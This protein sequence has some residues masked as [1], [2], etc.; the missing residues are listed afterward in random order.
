M[1][2]FLFIFYLQF[3]ICCSCNWYTWLFKLFAFIDTFTSNL[4]NSFVIIVSFYFTFYL[5]LLS[6]SRFLQSSFFNFYSLLLC[7]HIMLLKF[8]TFILSFA[9]SKFNFYF[10]DPLFASRKNYLPSYVF[11]SNLE[12]RICLIVVCGD[13]WDNFALVFDTY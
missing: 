7:I 9:F 4:S 3:L 11:S 13:C 8:Y 6:L 10:T 2:S 1:G 5:Y 12:G